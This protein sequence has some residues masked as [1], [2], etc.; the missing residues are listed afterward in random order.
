MRLERRIGLGRRAIGIA[1]L[2]R[3]ACE[4][5]RVGR[6]ADDDLG[7]GP[8]LGQHAGDAFERAAGAEASNPVVEFLAFE[9][10][11]DLARGGARMHVRVSL[12]L[13]LAGQEPAVRLGELGRLV[14]H[15]HAALGSGREHHLGAEEAHQLAPLDGK[16]LSHGQHQRIAL[17]RADH[18]QPD[19]G[20]AGGGFDDSLPGLELAG[21]FRRLDDAKRQA[22]LDRAERIEGLDLDVEVDAF[23][24]QLV[25]LDH[26]RVANGFE[27][28]CELG[29]GIDPSLRPTC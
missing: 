23:R 17:L 24:A 12:V 6:L 19:A 9:V 7:V 14:D 15:A 26:R 29:H 21:F 22:V 20:I 10:V 18:G 27:N 28:V 1:L 13:E 4:H 5:R 8:L 16:A 2:W 3:V 25:D 11:D